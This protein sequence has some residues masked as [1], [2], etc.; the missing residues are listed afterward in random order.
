MK[1]CFIS[2]KVKKIC[3]RSER[4]RKRVPLQKMRIRH[5]LAEQV[6]YGLKTLRVN[7]VIMIFVFVF[8]C[9]VC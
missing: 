3:G 7:A 4:K 1:E 6:P 9:I 5:K 8:Y 2:T